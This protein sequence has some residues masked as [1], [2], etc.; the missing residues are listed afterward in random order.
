MLDYILVYSFVDFFCVFSLVVI[1][2]R[3]T[4]GLALPQRRRAFLALIVS[5]ILYFFLN[6][7]FHIFDSPLQQAG[8]R[9]LLMLRSAVSFFGAVLCYFCFNYYEHVAD[10]EYTKV[11]FAKRFL[12]S[13][14]LWLDAALLIWNFFTKKFYS[15]SPDGQLV[16]EP[17]AVFLYLIPYTYVVYGIVRIDFTL[18]KEETYGF[19]SDYVFHA[20]L[21]VIPMATS[22]A[23]IFLPRIPLTSM[24]LTFAA[25]MIY[26]NS[27][28]QMISRDSLTHLN[29]KKEFFRNANKRIRKFREV[30]SEGSE[31]YLLMIDLDYFKDINDHY[32]HDE[33][34]IAICHFADALRQSVTVLKKRA[35]IARFGGDEF[36]MLFELTPEDRLDGMTPE[37]FVRHIRECIAKQNELY[38]TSYQ[39][40]ES[41]GC[42]RYRTSM[43]GMHEFMRVADQRMY[44][45][46]KKKGRGRSASGLF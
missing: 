1:G 22:I 31:I 21:P 15:F 18:L 29:N 14:I 38:H 5:M 4:T 16:Q 39:L 34:D 13:W 43:S 46:K 8:P 25:V 41:I 36:V 6:D 20:L 42:A 3:L 28:E 26:M 40:Q 23:E 2:I 45:E 10:S 9:Y 30:G 27:L 37:T 24:A 35:T 11:S 44:A 33:G 19:R 32:G 7:A 12:T 17:A